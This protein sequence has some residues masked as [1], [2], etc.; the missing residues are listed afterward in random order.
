ME[1]SG[2]NPRTEVRFAVVM[3]GGVSLAIY[4]NGVAQELF[5]LVRATA[6]NAAWDGLAIEDG[7]LSGIEAVY[8]E[9]G[10]T[11]TRFVVDI[12]SG[13]S[14]GGINGI[15]LAKALANGLESMDELKR[16]WID[17]G[18]IAELL[19]EP[20]AYK[21]LEGFKYLKPPASLLAGDRLLD[22][23]S[24]AIAAMGDR[25]PD[26]PHYADQVDLAVTMT[27]L[28]G[29][30][31][32][33]RLA[34]GT[35]LEPRHRA[36]L[37][38][39]YAT[40]DA[41]G[42][43][44]NDFLEKHD[45]MLAFAARATSSFPFA[46]SPILLDDI[47]PDPSDEER[48]LFNDWIQMGAKFGGFAFADGGYLQN[49]PF[50]HAT[51]ALNRRRADRPV[52]R[53]LLYVEPD[54]VPVPE[55]H[56]VPEPRPDV[57][58]NTNLALVGL[59]SAQPIRDDIE[60]I[61]ARNAALA[62]IE[63]VTRDIYPALVADGP[64][65]PL[66]ASGAYA[67]L[68]QAEVLDGLADALERATHLPQGG[69]ESALGRLL[70][71]YQAEFIASGP[72][73]YFQNLDLGF[74]LRRLVYLH[75][76]LDELIE[77]GPLAPVLVEAAGFEPSELSV[78]DPAPFLAAKQ[79]LN[80]RFRRLRT[81]GRNIRARGMGTSTVSVEAA[82]L[83][84]VCLTHAAEVMATQAPY[85][86]VKALVENDQGSE[87]VPALDRF[88]AAVAE[89][90][91]ACFEEDDSF[92][93]VA[94]EGASQ[95]QFERLAELLGR[96]H[97]RAVILDRVELPLTW[98]DLGEAQRVDVHRVSPRDAE[99]LV[100]MPSLGPDGKLTGRRRLAGVSLG[101]FG[102]F[103][104]KGWRYNDMLWG[105]LDGAERLDFRARRCQRRRW[106]E[107][108]RARRDPARGVHG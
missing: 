55:D 60:D 105:R 84:N 6:P 8:R 50:S 29:L 103:L 49:K 12:L 100:P 40:P 44:R 88:V 54:P 52:T 7:D 2:Y 78:T 57:L 10:G 63:A 101:H 75:R 87:I 26:A 76:V 81:V 43:A 59:P 24:K 70:L 61:E 23:A 69:Q 68:R 15:L 86:A 106:A 71:R 14:A 90:L 1:A 107:N 51:K 80:E 41:I 104:D 56:A 39:A 37:N 96:V 5:R 91:S 38:F 46:F 72:E 21:G 66:T 27:D 92:S 58:A 35:V 67:E 95:P 30:W 13:T 11:D 85:E 79:Q 18:D 4:I 99:S 22:R 94:D 53:K 19:N 89:E 42:L 64:D 47:A 45:R 62:R 108:P 65:P 33:L 98:P 77:H 82:H 34:D 36:V 74:R 73:E 31:L 48:R 97:R 28:Q 102:G 32:P 9:I 3:Y 83:A 17:E 93:L 16:L 25:T 20:N